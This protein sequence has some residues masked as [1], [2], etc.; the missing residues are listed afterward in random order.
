MELTGEGLEA[1]KRPGVW[2][3]FSSGIPEGLFLF[4]FLSHRS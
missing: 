1:M 4:I 3:A 2:V